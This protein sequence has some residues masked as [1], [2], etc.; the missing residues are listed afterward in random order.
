[1]SPSRKKCRGSP[2]L[3]QGLQM[4]L[5]R[6]P[7][8]GVWPELP[9]LAEGGPGLVPAP[10]FHQNEPQ[11]VVSRDELGRQP[12]DHPEG[13]LGLLEPV[14]VVVGPAQVV[15]GVFKVGITRDRQRLPGPPGGAP[16]PP[17]P[18]PSG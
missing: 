3:P 1:M 7:Q 11:M 4:L 16:P 13:L 14:E 10:R 17:P 12:E 2:P 18:R 5:G 8:G 15:V 9:G 6:Q